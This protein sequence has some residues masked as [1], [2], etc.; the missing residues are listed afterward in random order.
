MFGNFSRSWQLV[1]ASWAVLKSDKELILFP[2]ISSITLVV[3]TIITAIVAFALFGNSQS[4]SSISGYVGLFI[5]YFVSYTVII[6]FNTGL[7]GAAMSRLDGGDPTLSDGFRIANERIMNILGYA[8]IGATV[9]VVLRIIEQRAG[10]IGDIIA[11]IFG[12]AWNLATFL[13][14]PVLVATD[15]GPIDAVKHSAGL[16][17]K[18]WGEQIAGQFSIGGVFFL[19][20]LLAIVVGGLLAYAVGSV[21]GSVLFV[22]IVIVLTVIVIL[23]LATIQGALGGIYQAAL[24]R[25]AELGV[26]PDNF[27]IEIIEGAFKPKRKRGIF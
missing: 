20:Y 10:I 6:Y 3:V 11:G 23:I 4:S 19:F 27:D 12:L 15:M 9:G 24:Y 2:V 16:L 21:T 18:T 5:S 13:V 7:I 1:K 22:A 17:K 26:A 8:A 14:I 25:Y